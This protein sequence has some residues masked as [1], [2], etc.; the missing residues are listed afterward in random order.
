MRTILEQVHENARVY[1][2][3]IVYQVHLLNNYA[4]GG[5]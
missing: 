5:A 4:G 2:D 3:K 1:G